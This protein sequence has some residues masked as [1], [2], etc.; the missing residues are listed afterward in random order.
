[1]IPKG[2]VYLADC[3]DSTKEYPSTYKKTEKKTPQASCI[4][5][6]TTGIA[7]GVFSAGYPVCKKAFTALSLSCGPSCILTMFPNIEMP[8]DFKG[9]FSTGC[10]R[11]VTILR[12]TFSPAHQID[13]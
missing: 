3:L 1:M 12:K 7:V 10:I 9:L 11:D 6:A 5:K 8:D 13:R 4:E 2:L